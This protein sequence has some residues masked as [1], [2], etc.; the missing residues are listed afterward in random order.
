[1][2]TWECHASL[3]RF[4]C[5][6]HGS[7]S[8]LHRAVPSVGHPKEGGFMTVEKERMCRLLHEWLREVR[9]EK[10]AKVDDKK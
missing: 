6:R 9:E 2:V 1:M 7:P 4:F 5:D 8:V 3:P 10:E